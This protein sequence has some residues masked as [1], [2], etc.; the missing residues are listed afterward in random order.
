MGRRLLVV[1]PDAAGRAMMD[2]VLAAE[3]YA[4][5]AFGSVHDAHAPLDAG[6][7]ELAVVDELAGR[8]GVLEEIRWLRREHPTL[9]VVVT[10]ALLTSRVMRELLRLRAVD[11]LPKPFTPDDLREAVARGLREAA[12]RHD[13]AVE[14]AAAVT[15]ARR[16][17][18]RGA[19]ADARPSLVRAQAKAP[20]DAEITALW[21]LAAEIEGRDDEADRGYRAALALR[22]EE[23]LPP[24]DPFEGLARLAA[25]AGA[26]PA[27]SLPD[28]LRGAPVYIA[29]EPRTDLERLPAAGGPAIVLVA[30]GLGAEG[31]GQHPGLRADEPP[32]APGPGALF[33]RTREPPDRA[34]V[35]LSGAL[36]AESAAFA[37][38]RLGGGPARASE[39]TLGRLDLPGLH[40]WS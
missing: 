31:P 35:L 10:G 20:L 36:T 34:F 21:A 37:I 28:A 5:D 8:A 17:F 32:S 13:D 25:Y 11:A 15:A 26:R 16:A 2:R 7:F 40:P 38:D 29:G 22:I 33:F 30:I 23:G 27:A 4:A 14:Y 24:P 1:E 18:A 9:P 6:A 19:L 3:G 12:A 39:P